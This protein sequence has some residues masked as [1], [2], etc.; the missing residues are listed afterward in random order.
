M[1]ITLLLILKVTL[2]NFFQLGL[3]IAIW[4]FLALWPLKGLGGGKW[5]KI[6]PLS[7]LILKKFVMKVP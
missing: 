7:L 1:Q 2:L 4:P 6:R 3:D 5:K